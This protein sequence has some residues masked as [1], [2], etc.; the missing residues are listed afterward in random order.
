MRVVE[1]AVQ[2]QEKVVDG[3]GTSFPKKYFGPAADGFSELWSGTAAAGFDE[4]RLG[5][6]VSLIRN[7]AFPCVG[8]KS[9]IGRGTYRIGLH[10]AMGTASATGT[11]YE[12][13]RRFVAE[14]DSERGTLPPPFT[15][16]AAIFDG[17]FIGS[18]V[19]AHNLI[20]TQLQ[21]LRDIDSVSNPYALD[22][23]SEVEN[24]NFAMSVCRRA[25]FVVGLNPCASRWSRRFAY[26]ALV[27]NAHFQFQELRKRN[28]F[29]KIQLEIRN[30]DVRLQKSLNPN[31]S[32][33]GTV[34]EALQYSGM[35]VSDIRRCPFHE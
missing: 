34:S 3:T 7:P 10:D 25:F 27:F 13:L 9:A 15:T 14:Q 17:P 31:L 8:A 28:I 1:V 21:M 18:E 29:G 30:R 32:D 6:F 12:H 5:Q 26:P 33:H 16:Y 23:S 4:L 20:W 2:A 24:P 19:E 11:L 22:A 35:P